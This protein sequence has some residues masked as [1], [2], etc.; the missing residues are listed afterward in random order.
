M[1]AINPEMIKLARE[2]R[3]LNQ[4]D[5]CTLLGV[6]QGTISKIENGLMQ[7]SPE[8]I[9]NLCKVLDYPSSF[10]SQK[11]NVYATSYIYYRKRLSMTKKNLSVSEAKRNIIR[12]S[13]EKLLDSIDLPETNL[14]RWDIAT[15]GS[16]EDAAL[17]LREK[18]RIPKGKIDNLTKVIED[19]GIVIV[20]FD[21][22]GDKIDGISL[23]TEKN[24]PLI[25]VNNKLSPDRYR[26]T[27]AHELGH[28]IFHF[29][30]PIAEDRD[31]ELEAFKFASELLV[32]SIDFRRS[33]ENLDFKALTNLKLYWRVSMSS[34]VMKAKQIGSI[35]ENQAKYL[36]S[37]LSAL[38]FKLQ[39]P[40]ELSPAK[41]YPMLIKEILQV[42]K[43][44]LGYSTEDMGNLLHLNHRDFQDYFNLDSVRLRVVRSTHN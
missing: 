20:P 4:G 9:Q 21:F 18:W 11:D 12:I 38:G 5:L 8:L 37:Q 24:H 43:E 3:G 41:E 6:A 2:S 16:P 14:F 31:V 30:N 22:G 19:N 39:E 29:G 25:F 32:P 28:L 44:Q 27:V 35:T 15:H 13:I 7:P 23:Y 34:L 10:F 26:L 40:P 1:T 17:L 42:Y 36:F 33:F